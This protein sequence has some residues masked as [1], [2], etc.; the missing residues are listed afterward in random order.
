MKKFIALSFTL[1]CVLSCL[2]GLTACEKEPGNVI[3]HGWKLTLSLKSTDDNDRETA[4][5]VLYERENAYEPYFTV[6]DLKNGKIEI[7]I[8]GVTTENEALLRIGDPAVTP[9]VTLRDADGKIVLTSE[10]VYLDEKMFGFCYSGW[11]YP[12]DEDGETVLSSR[13]YFIDDKL[14][15]S[16]TDGGRLTSVVTEKGKE[17]IFK[18][19]GW[20]YYYVGET[21][22]LHVRV[23]Y[24]NSQISADPSIAGVPGFLDATGFKTKEEVNA[25]IAALRYPPLSFEYN[26]LE[27]KEIN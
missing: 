3:T 13:N 6:K 15:E 7:L 18:T 26:I 22:Y 4:L 5:N 8:D 16:T 21:A 12:D 17:E 14:F 10:D 23:L 19:K 11:N 9:A 2:F 25:L 20:L 24:F 27:S 1:L